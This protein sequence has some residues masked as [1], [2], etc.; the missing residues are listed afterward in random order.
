M[1][2]ITG[3]GVELR[4]DIGEN[5]IQP[6]GS[7]ALRPSLDVRLAFQPCDGRAGPRSGIG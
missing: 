3:I 1:R 6:V 4:L 2:R 7:D 5:P